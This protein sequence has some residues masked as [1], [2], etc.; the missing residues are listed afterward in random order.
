MSIIF[1]AVIYLFIGYVIGETI[2]ETRI[3]KEWNDHNDKIDRI[4]NRKP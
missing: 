3:L 4:R 1:I 2:G